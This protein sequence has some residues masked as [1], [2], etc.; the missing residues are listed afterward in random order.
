MELPRQS[1][2]GFGGHPITR[3][4][5]NM[6]RLATNA[7]SVRPTSFTFLSRFQ[8]QRL[9]SPKF[10]S[11]SCSCPKLKGIVTSLQHETTFQEQQ[12]DGNSNEQPHALSLDLYSKSSYAV[13]EQLQK[14]SPTM[15]PKSKELPRNSYDVTEFPKFAF[16]RTI[17]K[18]TEL[19]NE[20]T[21]RYEKD[22]SRLAKAF[23]CPSMTYIWM[24]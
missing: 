24:I 17:L 2:N 13:M 15:D 8:H 11:T 22:L 5:N 9:S 21:L 10:I 6:S 12:K 7:R 19:S 16:R 1:H 14:S 20:D 4:L 18:Q 23:H 3:T